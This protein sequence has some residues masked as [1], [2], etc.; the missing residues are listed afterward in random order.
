MKKHIFS[1]I[2]ILALALSL[3]SCNDDNWNPNTDGTSKQ[4]TLSLKGLGVNINDAEQTV[5]ASRSGVDLSNYIVEITKGDVVVQKWT[6]ALMPEVLTLNEG[7]YTVNVSSHELQD[8]E[9]EKPFYK[10]SKSFTITKGDVTEI[11][12]VT[13]TFQSVRVSVTFTDDLKTA[14]HSDCK[15]VI[16]VGNS[17]TALEFDKDHYSSSA[18]FRP[19]EGSMTLVATFKGTVQSNYTETKPYTFT[20]VTAG[21][22]YRL[23]FSAKGPNPIIPDETGTIDLGSGITLDTDILGTEN[24]DGSV[25]NPEGTVGDGDRPGQ[26][27]QKEDPDKPDEPTPPVTSNEITISCATLS[28]DEPNS[29]NVSPL[30]AGLVLLHA[31]AKIAHLFV[32][33][34]SSDPGFAAAVSE[35]LP[36]EFDLAYPGSYADTFK[37]DLEFPVGN[38]VLG[39]SDLEFDITKFIPL[40]A[41]FQ[42]TH[43]FTI[44]IEDQG[45]PANKKSETLVFT[46][47]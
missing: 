22:H 26:E 24:I 23:N 6:Y 10:G 39:Q 11:G 36:M 44:S 27:G 38:E 34:E 21:K 28:F 35:F 42:G 15:V 29:L 16:E 31:D 8:A 19:V 47:K 43:S 3:S 33:I 9:W 45:S 18:Y 5:A 17:G 4:G 30:P 40:L 12:T 14:M 20:D 7:E 41:G 2:T 37:N 32:K 46:V 25:N 1:I 13:C